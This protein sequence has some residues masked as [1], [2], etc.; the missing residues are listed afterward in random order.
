M[1]VVRSQRSEIEKVIEELFGQSVPPGK[2]QRRI[3]HVHARDLPEIGAVRHGDSRWALAWGEL[4]IPRAPYGA[5]VEEA[6]CSLETGREKG[7]TP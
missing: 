6:T 5:T 1:S 3:S 2:F 4:P 7:V